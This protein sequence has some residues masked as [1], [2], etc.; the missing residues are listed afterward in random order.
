M[1]RRTLAETLT[2]LVEGATPVHPGL[3]VEEAEIEL[4]LIVTLEPTRAGPA[5]LRAQPPSSAFR[6]GVDPVTHRIRIRITQAAP[7][8]TADATRAATRATG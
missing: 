3:V 2:A 4:P 7:Q 1:T 5:V 6:S 8:D